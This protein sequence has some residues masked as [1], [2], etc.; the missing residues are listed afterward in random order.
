M[1]FK[2]VI[3]TSGVGSRL[4]KITDYTNKCLVRV[5]K[6]PAISH[7]IESYPKETDFVI[8][9]GYFGNQVKDFLEIAYSDKNFEFVKIEKFK[10][11]GSS[12]LKSLYTA[13]SKLQCPFIF[14]AC[15]TILYEKLPPPKF[16]WISGFKME[17]STSYASL[18]VINS[19]VT[20]VHKKGHL[21]FDYIHVGVIGI[22]NFDDFW[23]EAKKLIDEKENDQTIGDV[24]VLQNIV[25]KLDFTFFKLSSWLDIGSVSGLHNARKKIKNNEFKVLDKLAESIFLIDNNFIKFFHDKKINLNRVHREKFLNG[26]IPKIIDFKDNFYKY[27]AVDGNIF[28][29]TANRDNIKSLLNWA[30]KSLWK[31]VKLDNDTSFYD[32]C[33]KFYKDKTISRIK[34]FF[35]KKNINDKEYLINGESC[36]KIFDLIDEIDFEE[37]SKGK[38][39]NFHGDFILDNILHVNN[40]F[41]L[42]DWR[43]DFQGNLEVGDKYYDLAKFSHNLV[44]NHSIVDN[45]LFKVEIDQDKINL[46]I[47][48]LQTLV[49]GELEFFKYLK[50]KKYDISKVKLIRALIWLNMSPL[51]HH[52]FDLFLFYF[53]TYNLKKALHDYKI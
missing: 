16:N 11:E 3:T 32:N 30:E 6:K 42:I 35:E 22:N 17:D 49:E 14:H 28:S 43:Q 47:H 13:K 50:N 39:T 33:Y 46:N 24:D 51:H 4:G 53:G 41:K 19:K 34:L 18:T 52:P 29:E 31:E 2:V 12:L 1:K 8:T 20:D 37:I 26:T 38:P 5:G 21:N 27:E 40:S 7:I 23:E 25:K 36:P 48:R 44:V 10:G 9:I 15:D 45:D